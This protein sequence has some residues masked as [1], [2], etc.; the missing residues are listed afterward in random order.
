MTDSFARAS[1]IV[2]LLAA[3]EVRASLDPSA[4]NPPAVLVVPPT[5]AYDVPCGFTATWTLI[6]LAPGAQGAD[7]GTWAALDRLVD[8]V[9]DA[10]PLERAEMAAYTLNGQ[11]LPAYVCT[12]TEAL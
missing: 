6:A 2:A 8:A 9:A 10:V 11:T 4:V 7:R 12:F 5:R 1:D 3:A